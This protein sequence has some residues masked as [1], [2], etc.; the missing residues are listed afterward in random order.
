MIRVLKWLFVVLGLV[1]TVVVVAYFLAKAIWA[2]TDPPP[3]FATGRRTVDEVRTSTTMAVAANPYAARAGHEILKAGGTAVDA[4]IAMQAVLTLV[5]PQS[6]GI[7]GGAFM[8]LFD[9][10]DRSLTAYDGRE[11]APA[12]VTADLFVHEDG[13][14]FNFVEAVVGGRSVG[15]P[16]VMRMLEVAHKKHGR[17]PWPKLF[18][19]AIQLCEDGFEV[20]ARLHSL[21]RLDPLFRTQPAARAYL[22]QADGRALPVG[23]VLKNPKLAR[24]LRAMAKEGADVL[25][26]GPIAEAIVKAV[27]TARRPSVTVAAINFAMIQNM[28]APYGSGWQASVD[29]A[30]YLTLE[31][32]GG[33]QPKLREPV[34]VDYHQ[35]RVCGFGPPTSGGITTL[36]IIKML[37]RFELA[38]LSPR[39]AAY[40]HLLA[41][42]SKLAFADRA[43]YI[44]DP[45]F[46]DVPVAGLLDPEYLRRRSAMIKPDRASRPAEAGQPA[47]V[48][49]AFA[50]DVDRS[51]P[52]TSH[53]VVVDGE[54]N[55]VSMTTSV[56]NVF[57]SRMMVEG[58]VLNNQLTDFSF[59][60]TRNGR[61]VANAV[62]PGKRPRSSM[63]PLIIME[64]DTGRPVFAIGSPGGSRIIVYTARAALGMLGG[65]TPQQA[66]E[67]PHVVNRNGATELEDDGWAAGELDRVRTELEAMGHTVKVSPQ[68]SGLHA[69]GIAS[70]GLRGGA[71]P[72]REGLAAGD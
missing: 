55:V 40:A 6:S 21:L 57:G 16:G 43:R 56:E 38:K 4:A 34:C 66:V 22:Y 47:G 52:S 33:Y 60:P 42:A 39:S 28:G 7:G 29:N 19:P 18:A 15:V 67:L 48:K 70:D 14:P 11:T 3:E 41:E 2:D 31:D 24:V 61:P 64:R 50:D 45:D 37:E 32:L 1:V 8:L 9:A 62:A 35:W 49:T 65:L 13:T 69:V 72:R 54:R 27:R 68:N 5:E 17:L 59:V 26:Q 10:Q 71:D 46:V 36:Q 58:F 23:T 12:G 51:R 44:G 53:L 20:S 30:G 63:S 25:H